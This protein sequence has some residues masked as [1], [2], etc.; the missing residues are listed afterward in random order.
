M[1]GEIQAVTGEAC[2]AAVELLVRFFREE[3]F[4]T[5]P[6]RI[7]E[8]LDQMLADP[9]C[10]CALAVEGGAAQAVVTV[11]TLLYVEWGRLGEIG[12]LYVLPE[13]RHR[14]LARRLHASS[15]RSTTSAGSTPRSDTGASSNSR[16]NTPARLSIQ[17]P[18]P[19]DSPICHS[20]CPSRML[21]EPEA[22]PRLAGHN[23]ADGGVRIS[24][25]SRP[26]HIRWAA[27]LLVLLSRGA[28]HCR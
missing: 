24:P 2:D 4:A 23:H 27:M 5:P 20:Y 10:R 15:T 22:P 7:A 26:T 28:G 14:G 17:H 16:I 11:S 18:N 9:S 1:P 25:G 21:G 8:N 13:H 19:P 6:S 3:G 12:D